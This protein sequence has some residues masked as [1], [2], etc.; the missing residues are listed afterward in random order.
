[1]S[2]FTWRSVLLWCGLFAIGSLALIYQAKG[3]Y[4]LVLGPDDSDA[5]DL[6][7]R[8]Q[9]Q[10]F[11]EQGKNPHDYMTGSQP[12]WGYPVGWLLT[13]PKWPAV[14]IYF[15]V[16]NIVAQ[17]VIAA[18]VW[19]FSQLARLEKACLIL[20]LLAFGG[21]CTATEVGQISI[22]VTALL[23][24]ALW[25]DTAGKSSGCGL[26]VALS[27]V[28]PTISLPFVA[29]ILMTRRW[30]ALQV[31]V[32]YCA[33][34]TTFC[35]VVTQTT[36]WHMLR[37]LAEKAAD[38]IDH[39]TIGLVDVL[40]ACGIPPAQITLL[41]PLLVVLPSLLCMLLC[42]KSLLISFAIAAVG[43]RLWTYHKSYDDIMLLFLL[44]PLGWLACRRRSISPALILFLLIGILAWLPGRWLALREVQL[45]QLVAWPFAL[46]YILT[47]RNEFQNCK[48]SELLPA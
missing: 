6:F 35:W 5:V 1:M 46:G 2:G 10:G 13:W 4:L 25:C 27:L 18:W 37:Q 14:R 20:S 47:K 30:I 17:A 34:A 29:A 23:V 8:T 21:S 33:A 26:L 31:L 19:R 42:R 39:G 11:F 45:L 16:I 41:T 24:G 38:Y 36:P 48:R 9:E 43:G 32:V 40:K 7:H 22:V 3:N 15:A 44:F 12:P 28:K